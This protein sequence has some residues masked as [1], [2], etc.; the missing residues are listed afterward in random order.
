[1]NL[2]SS[3][4]RRFY[5][6]VGRNWD[7]QLFRQCIETYI[8]DDSILLDLGAGS[9]I[10]EAMNFRC[11]VHRACGIDLDERVLA[12]PF[13]DEAKVACG[14][15]IPYLN[16]AFDVVI[17]DNVLEHLEKPVDV[18]AEIVR[19]LKPGGV[20]L[21]KTPNRWHYVA[22]IASLSPHWF[23]SFVNRWR[24]RPDSQFFPTLYRANSHDR[25]SYC[26]AL[27][28]LTLD[29]LLY[30]DGRPEYLRFSWPTYLLGIAYQKLCN[31]SFLAPLRVGLIGVLRKPN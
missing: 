8:D 21:F 1:M 28:G 4:D 25:I 27:A 13:L 26:S 20:F 30:I 15:S 10:V 19:V 2:V 3:L 17:A 9:G 23:H 22:L 31:L 6:G 5:P 29:K 7:D 24:G 18:F 11:R 14:S 12:N 16:N